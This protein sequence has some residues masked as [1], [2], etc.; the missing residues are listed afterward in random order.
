MKKSKFAPIFAP[1][2]FVNHKI[3]IQKFYEQIPMYDDQSFD[4][5]ERTGYWKFSAN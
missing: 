1:V 5:K 3:S 2:F 4:I